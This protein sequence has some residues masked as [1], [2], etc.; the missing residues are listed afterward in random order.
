MAHDHGNEYQVRFAHE[1]GTEALSQWIAREDVA[2]A[3]AALH[4]PG[5]KAYWLR[6]RKVLCP[7]CLDT[8]QRI[9][10][11]PLVDKPSPQ[12]RVPEPRWRASRGA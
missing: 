1:N 3:M 4:R 6:E 8:E 10:E 2:Q 9:V 5:V 11:Y 7:N 12:L